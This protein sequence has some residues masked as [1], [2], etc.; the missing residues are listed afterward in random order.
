MQ[1]WGCLPSG[2][3]S[4]LRDED[5]PL[6]SREYPFRASWKSIAGLF[7]MYI[8]LHFDLL[9]TLSKCYVSFHTV[10]AAIIPKESNI[11]NVG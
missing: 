1:K 4:D 10:L 3:S 8:R 11:G 5:A 7:S 9:D 2:R 6:S